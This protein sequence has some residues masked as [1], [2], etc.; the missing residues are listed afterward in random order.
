MHHSHEALDRTGGLGRGGL[1]GPLRQRDFRLLWTGACTSLLGD[2]AFLVALA[3][4]VYA[5]GGGPAGMSLVG[6]AMT[7]ATIAFLLVGGVASGP[8]DRRGLLL[9]A[10]PLRAPAGGPPPGA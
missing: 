4:Q 3:W 2:G 9:A 1:T 10:D 7:V 6:I 5:L 8:L